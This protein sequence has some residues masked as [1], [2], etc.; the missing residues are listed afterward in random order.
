[1]SL[2]V[3]AFLH[4]SYLPSFIINL[5]VYVF[6]AEPLLCLC[7][8]RYN[9]VCSCAI[10]VCNSSNLSISKLLYTTEYATQEDVIFFIA[11]YF[12]ISK[13]SA[14]KFVWKSAHSYNVTSIQSLT[15][16]PD[17]SHE[18]IIRLGRKSHFMVHK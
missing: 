12:R 9:C 11:F 5:S 10:L 8:N 7:L 17:L 6:S 14:E 1:M 18:I 13:S 3:C 16:I 4:S 15:Y 2:K